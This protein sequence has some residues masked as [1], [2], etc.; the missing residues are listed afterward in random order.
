MSTDKSDIEGTRRML[1][2]RYELFDKKIGI[3]INKVPK[4]SLSLK[5]RNNSIQLGTHQL[6]VIGVIPCSCDIAIAGRCLFACEK[7]NHPFTERL[8]EIATN[9]ELIGRTNEK[10]KNDTLSFGFSPENDLSH[11]LLLQPVL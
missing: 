5:I 8:R 1:C 11:K 3:I 7:L 6:P 2:D 10:C 4:E 9:L